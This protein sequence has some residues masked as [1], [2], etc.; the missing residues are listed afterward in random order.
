MAEIRRVMQIG[1]GFRA[2]IVRRC[3][4]LG[5]P[6]GIRPPAQVPK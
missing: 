2:A 4:V 6:A 3:T 5:R 1:N